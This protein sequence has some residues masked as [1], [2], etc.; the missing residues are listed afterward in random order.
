MNKDLFMYHQQRQQ[1]LIE[2]VKAK[3]LSE[4]VEESKNVVFEIRN[5]YLNRIDETKF[6]KIIRKINKKNNLKER[7]NEQR[8]K[9]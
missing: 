6:L 4:I 5:P 7:K 1:E 9:I 2:K 3:S 8:N